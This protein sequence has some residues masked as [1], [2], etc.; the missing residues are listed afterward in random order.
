MEA[1]KEREEGL[2]SKDLPLKVLMSRAA[3]KLFKIPEKGGSKVGHIGNFAPRK[4]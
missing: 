4:W 3:K 2:L 1:E